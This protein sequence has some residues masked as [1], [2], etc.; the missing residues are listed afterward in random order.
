VASGDSFD[1]LLARLRQGESQAAAQVH[2]EFTRRL[3]ALARS[4]LEAQILAKED[5]DDVVQSV[6]KSF[7]VRQQ[8]GE[9]AISD[10]D[11]LWAV[12]ATITVRKCI[13]RREH[14]RAARRDVDRERRTEATSAASDDT[15]RG[16]ADLMAAREPLPEEAAELAE[17][18][19]QL[20][21]GFEG[22]DRQIAVLLLQGEPHAEIARN[23]ARAE[24]TVRR[25]AT[26][27][28]RRIERLLDSSHDRS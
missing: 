12:L 4:R 2:A 25:V 26:E 21:A 16:P 11:G 24:R 14:Y 10:R 6:Y 8:A 28:K 7:F 20:L 5:P 3:C 13:N 15:V 19:E 18:V 22:L 9:F 27:L 23:T 17:T 1:N